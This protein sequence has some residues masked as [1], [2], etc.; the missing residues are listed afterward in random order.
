[1]K[2]GLLLLLFGIPAGLAIMPCRGGCNDGRREYADNNYC[3]EPQAEYAYVPLLPL[4][5]RACSSSASFAGDG[6]KHPLVTAD[7]GTSF[8]LPYPNAA[9]TL[10]QQPFQ[11]SPPALASF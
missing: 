2:T 11:V 9:D 8:L 4:D 3:G 5:P 7:G 10:V 1:M 6:Q